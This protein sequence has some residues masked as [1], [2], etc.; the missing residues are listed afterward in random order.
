ML[1]LPISGWLDELIG[2]LAY[3]H[4]LPEIIPVEPAPDNAGE[5]NVDAAFRHP[6]KTWEPRP[7]RSKGWTN[8][9]AQDLAHAQFRNNFRLVWSRPYVFYR[10][11]R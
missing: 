9:K 10:L 8:E 7:P 1:S 3:K 11:F 2:P 6:S 4:I 5:G